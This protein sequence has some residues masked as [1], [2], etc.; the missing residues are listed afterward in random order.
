[1]TQDSGGTASPES[2][3][4][5]RPRLPA[6]QQ[7]L[8]WLQRIDENRVYSNWGPLVTGFSARLCRLFG[9]PE[10]GDIL[11]CTNSGMSALI[12]AILGSAGRASEGRPLAIVPDFTFTATGQAVQMCGFRPVLADCR[13]DT[14]TLHPDD[15]LAQ[16]GL[17]AR[18]GLVVPVAPFGR[19]VAQQAWL[20]FRARTGIPVVIDAAACFDTFI[21]AD[22]IPHP[23]I[24][25]LPVALSFHATKVF[26][27][28]E[29][30][31]VICTDAALAN[32][33]WQSLNFGFQGSRNSM[34]EGLNGK[35]SEYAAA[36][37][38]AEL[39][40]WTEKR[41]GFA[42]AF[43]HYRDVFAALG[44]PGTLYGPPAISAAYVLLD[45]GS[46]ER[47]SQLMRALADQHID[48]RLWYGEGL[49]AHTVFADAQRLPLACGPALQ[50]AS[51]LGLPVAPDLGR[52]RIERIG[53]AIR[54]VPDV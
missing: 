4:V 13:A 49:S 37:G 35:M 41:Q 16:P 32:R 31:A 8:P 48:T 33:I 46:V 51:L 39:E 15:L 20:D 34:V 43:A 10:G 12:G 54:H 22:G 7:L 44:I 26:A 53:H 28:G 50:A 52:D 47:C 21:P 27:T 40:G 25:P 14:W 3:P 45:C 17:L 30:G 2:I 29:G 38:L 9:L 36:V 18:T 1:M 6:A 19:P 42:T 5:L 11:T 23:G 24:G